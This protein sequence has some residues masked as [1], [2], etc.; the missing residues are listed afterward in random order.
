MF[1][2]SW[3]FFIFRFVIE[4]IVKFWSR[5][6]IT[7]LFAFSFACV[8]INLLKSSSCTR[9]ESSSRGS[10]DVPAAKSLAL[11][12]QFLCYE[13]EAG[14]ERPSNNLP[15]R[16]CSFIEVVFTDE[17]I[18]DIKLSFNQN[19]WLR[20]QQML[21]WTWF[22]LKF[23]ASDSFETY[24]TSGR[25]SILALPDSPFSTSGHLRNPSVR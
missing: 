16:W 14:A 15:A 18:Y 4:F 23:N 13:G 25:G 20:A 21:Y 19:R 3:L 24:W 5:N 17:K 2:S 22:N 9:L 12:F 10:W 1:L 7:R 11:N 8:K 6:C